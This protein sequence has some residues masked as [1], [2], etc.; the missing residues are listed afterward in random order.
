MNFNDVIDILDRSVGGPD[1]DVSSHGPFWRGVT[2]ER[3]VTM[4]VG[5]RKLVTLGDGANSSL[6]KSLKG[7]APFGSDLAPAPEGAT[8]MRMPAYLDPV[9]DAEIAQIAQWIDEGCPE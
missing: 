2:R 3:F 6:I 7:L 4:K 1:A 9:S 8:V 5:G